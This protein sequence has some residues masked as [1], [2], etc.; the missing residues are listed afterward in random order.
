MTTIDRT[1]FGRLPVIRVP[2]R[3]FIGPVPKPDLR[4]S[5]EREKTS[6]K[7]L[8]LGCVRRTTQKITK[9]D[10][11]VCEVVFT[12]F[13]ASTVKL[14]LTGVPRKTAET[15]PISDFLEVAKSCCER[16]AGAVFVEITISPKD[17]L[18][19]K[20]VRVVIC[21]TEK[22]EKPVRSASERC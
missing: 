5:E 6:R 7:E 1:N 10:W 11:V 20:I 8:T 21:V 4:S 17:C 18:P 22:P 16:L 19:T 15:P 13:I 2:I 3:V 9:V 12:Y 14:T